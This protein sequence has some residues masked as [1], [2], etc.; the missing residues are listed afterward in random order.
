MAASANS[1]VSITT[2]NAE[3]GSNGSKSYTY[4]S[5]TMYATKD[6]SDDVMHVAEDAADSMYTAE[7]DSDVSGYNVNTFP[8]KL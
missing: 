4:N 2:S 7:D 8:H 1:N 6:N 3:K 5:D